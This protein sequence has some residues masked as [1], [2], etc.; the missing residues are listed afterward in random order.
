LNI[1]TNILYLTYDGL[2]DPLG[3]SQILPYLE[4]LSKEGYS[5]TIISFE[6]K[7]AFRQRRA[8][9]EDIVK[10]NNIEWHPLPYHK[11]PPVLSTLYDIFRLYKKSTALHRQK[12]FIIVHCRSYITSLIGLRMLKKYKIRFIFDMRGFWA[13][14]RVD[15]GL[16]NLKNPVYRIIYNFFKRAE[17]Q[18]L[19]EADHIVALTQ[20]A[21][22]EIISWGILTPVSVIPCC[23]DLSLFNPDRISEEQKVKLRNALGISEKQIVL[24]YLGSLGT[25][26]MV[27]EMLSF[28]SILKEREPDAK[29]LI[30][31]PDT[32]DFQKQPFSKDIILKQAERKDVPAYISLAYA[33][34]FF[35]KPAFSKKAS[36]AT[37]MAE[38]MAMHIPV[39]TNTGWGDAEHIINEANAGVLVYSLDMKNY[40][41]AVDSLISGPRQS[42][43]D[44]FVIKEQFS[45]TKGVE[46][47][48]ALYQDV[49]D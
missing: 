17:Q 38:L 12:T 33:S 28:F 2:T 23:V 47:Y 15:G 1:K 21:R 36:S 24:L 34:V 16:W 27:N 14:E 49:T 18:F 3:Q 22:N 19:N 31:S 7:K 35:I 39:I 8:L 10:R 37:K 29:F 4:G 9:I 5:F 26:Y 43:A 11:F 44:A 45:L 6:K 32:W 13:D 48:K 20:N 30:L 46:L 42:Y 40:Q 25:W 41:K